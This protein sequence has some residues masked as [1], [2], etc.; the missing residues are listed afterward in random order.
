MSVYLCIALHPYMPD[1]ARA[2]VC[3]YLYIFDPYVCECVCMCMSAIPVY[4]ST[5][6]CVRV[7]LFRHVMGCRASGTKSTV[8][9]DVLW[10]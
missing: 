9:S 1:S 4:K 10:F 2:C 8:L 6:V 5:F 7:Y 3:G